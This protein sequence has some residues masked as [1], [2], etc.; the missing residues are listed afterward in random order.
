[1][2]VRRFH[3]LESDLDGLD[4]FKKWSVS[5]KKPIGDYDISLVYKGKEYEDNSV[6]YL[7]IGKTVIP[8][9]T[10]ENLLDV[11]RSMDEDELEDLRRILGF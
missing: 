1:M 2:K 11:I 3:Q 8:C 9:L 4:I 7:A 10:K 6:D 5:D